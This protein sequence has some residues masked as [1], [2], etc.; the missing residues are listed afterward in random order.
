MQGKWPPEGEEMQH[1]TWS[2]KRPTPRERASRPHPPQPSPSLPRPVS[3]TQARRW[4]ARGP[5][6]PPTPRPQPLHAPAPA[7]NRARAP[8]SSA[9]PLSGPSAPKV[10][11]VTV[12]SRFLFPHAQSRSP[13]S[14]GGSERLGP[15]LQGAARQ[16]AAG[17]AS[18]ASVAARSARLSPARIRSPRAPP[19]LPPLR[20]PGGQ[21]PEARRAFD[22]PSQG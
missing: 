14:G 8:G 21:L 3:S 2:E 22:P 18:A 17:A 6:P 5:V 12:G 10:A 16:W 1:S 11:V 20:P 19:S 13:D 4:A 9:R 15:S 7:R